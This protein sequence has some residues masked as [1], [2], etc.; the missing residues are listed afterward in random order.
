MALAR[1]FYYSRR[2]KA[3]R[4]EPGRILE[5]GAGSGQF[6]TFATDAGLVSHY[7][8]VD[9]PEMLLNSAATVA[10]KLPQADIR[11]GEAPD[12]SA[13]GLHFWLLRPSEIALIPDRSLDA[14]LNFN[15]FMEMDDQVRDAYIGHIYRTCS[16]GAA[17]Y[18]VNRYQQSM[19]RRDGSTFTGNPLLYPYRADD[20]VIEWGVDEMQHTLRARVFHT[21]KSFSISRIALI[22]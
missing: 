3:V 13:P 7:V 16:P 12:F 21:P 2:L 22:R 8:I 17:F 14:G 19:A 9:L 18:N 11:A 10:R 4:A 6:A 15:S 20:E 5:I 1:H